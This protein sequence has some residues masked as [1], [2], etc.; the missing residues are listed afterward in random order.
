[1]TVNK[2]LNID[3]YPLPTPEDIFAMLTGTTVF[4]ASDLSGAYQQ[5]KVHPEFKKY[6]TINTH[7]GMFRYT[8]LTYGIAS[9]PAIFQVV[10][11]QILAGLPNVHC[12][13]DDI[14]IAGCAVLRSQVRHWRLLK[15]WCM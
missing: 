2:V 4:T 8:R 9:A 10:M 1:M 6:L 13:L 14:M 7:I 12:Y 11:D 5:L 15:I 3:Q